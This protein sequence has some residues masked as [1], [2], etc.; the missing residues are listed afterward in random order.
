MRRISVVG[1]SGSKT[2]L[3]K[4]IGR[5]LSIPHVELD[6][7]FWGRN[8][9]QASDDLFR[10]KTVQALSD[11]AWVVDGNYRAVRSLVWDRAD[12]VIW[13]DYS[14]PVILR[15]LVR[16]TAGLIVTQ[17]GLWNGNR[18][19]LSNAFFSRDSLIWYM[20]KT[21]RRRRRQFSALLAAPEQA[22]DP[23][24]SAL[25]PGRRGMAGAFDGK[26]PKLTEINRLLERLFFAARVYFRRVISFYFPRVTEQGRGHC[27]GP[28]LS[29]IARCL[30]VLPGFSRRL[31]LLSI[32]SGLVQA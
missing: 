6:A 31:R 24:S 14:L 13:L 20:L 28:F 4:Q 16:R 12:T 10:E 25:A 26:S 29:A 3:A 11:D 23:G 9:T 1:T 30:R 21:Y 17:A 5:T 8:W 19:R 15:R 32:T 7:L 22:S 18:E 2:T 27:P